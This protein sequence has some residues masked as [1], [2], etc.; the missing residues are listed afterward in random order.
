MEAIL[1]KSSTVTGIKKKVGE[2]ATKKGI[3][4]NYKRQNRLVI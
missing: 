3:K 2:W 1:A 4:G